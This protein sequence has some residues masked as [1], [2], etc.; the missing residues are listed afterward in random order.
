MG[1]ERLVSGYRLGRLEHIT[2]P[3]PTTYRIPSSP[4]VGEGVL[5]LPLAVR[6]EILVRMGGLYSPRF[7]RPR[8]QGR[9]GTPAPTTRL[10]RVRNICRRAYRHT[11]YDARWLSLYLRFPSSHGRG[12]GDAAPYG[13]A[14][15]GTLR[16]SGRVFGNLYVYVRFRNVY[17]VE[18][19]KGTFPS[20]TYD[21]LYASHS[22]PSEGERWGA[23]ILLPLFTTGSVFGRTPPI[24]MENRPARHRAACVI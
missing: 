11:R 8:P 7:R 9:A 6:R 18:V 23:F 4:N 20:V 14:G 17:S 2:Q 12:V 24:T 15:D 1:G 21:T 19:R 3:F 13:W 10:G 22:A 5:T 16:N